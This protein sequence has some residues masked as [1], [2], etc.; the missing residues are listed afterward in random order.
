MSSNH[1]NYLHALHLM[2]SKSGVPESEIMAKLPFTLKDTAKLWYDN[3]VAEGI[4]PQTLAEWS[5]AIC[6]HFEND[7]WQ[8]WIRRKLD[9]YRYPEAERDPGIWIGKFINYAR[10]KSPDI[11][12]KQLRQ[13]IA[14]AMP[15]D[16]RRLVKASAPEGCTIIEYSEVFMDLADT[17]HRPS[18]SVR[19]EDRRHQAS[20]QSF[21]RNKPA[22]A[23]SSRTR[24]ST[25]RDGSGST[26][27]RDSETVRSD[28][29]QTGSTSATPDRQSS[30][31]AAKSNQKCY[32]CG[33]T[34]HYANDTKFHPRSQQLNAAET[35]DQ[36]DIDHTAS[37]QSAD[38]A[39]DQRSASDSDHDPFTV[40]A[41]DFDLPASEPFNWADCM[42]E[43]DDAEF[44]A[45]DIM[46]FAA[47]FRAEEEAGCFLFN[48]PEAVELDA[49]I[50]DIDEAQAIELQAIEPARNKPIHGKEPVFVTPGQARDLIDSG[51]TMIQE[52]ILDGNLQ[53]TD[54]HRLGR[55]PRVVTVINNRPLLVMIDSGA[56][57]SVITRKLLEEIE[58]HYQLQLKPVDIPAVV[59]FGTRIKPTGLYVTNVIFPHPRGNIQIQAAFLVIDV[60]GPTQILLGSDMT[61]MYGIDLVSSSGR[62]MKIGKSNSRFAIQLLKNDRSAHAEQPLLQLMAAHARAQDISIFEEALTAA[63]FSPNL[64]D[65]EKADLVRMLIERRRA[66]AWGT[67]QLGECKLP[68]L[69]LDVTIPDPIP[70]RLR[71]TPYPASPKTKQDISDMIDTLL[72]L[73]VIE[74]S[75]SPYAAPVVMVYQEGKGRL[76]VN[77]KAM[78]DI[79]VAF[80][81]PLPRMNETLAC[82]GSASYITVLDLNRGFYQCWVHPDSVQ[83]LTFCSHRGLFQF[84]RMPMGI[85]NGPA[86]FQYGMDT[87]LG[88]WLREGWVKV[89]LDDVIIFSPSFVEHVR[90][91]NTILGALE[92]AGMTVSIKKCQF[93]FGTL[94]ALGR[95]VSGL[96]LAIDPHKTA[97]VD[98]W[99]RPQNVKQLMS[100]SGFINY[101]RNHIPGLAKIMKPM[102]TLLLKDAS[103]EWTDA[104]E[105]AFIASKKALLS[106]EVLAM[107]DF[108]KPFKLYVDASFEGLGGE[109]SQLLQGKERPICFISRRLRP[110]EERYGA[111]QL[112]CLCLIWALEK[113]YFYLD[114]AEFTVYTD[115]QAI[116]S[117]MSVKNPNRHMLRWQ[118]AIQEHRGQMTVVHRAGKEN[119][120]ADGLSRCALPNDAS[121]PAADLSDDMPVIYAVAIVDMSDE[122]LRSVSAGMTQD[123][124]LARIQQALRKQTPE[125]KKAAEVDLSADMLKDFQSGRFFLLDDVLYRRQGLTSELVLGDT[126]N[127]QTMLK[128]CHDAITSG[129]FGF[130]KTYEKVKQ[131]AW[132]PHMADDIRKYVETCN[133]CQMS[134]RATGK[135]QGLLM[136]IETPTHPW[137][138]IHMDFVTALPPAGAD[139]FNACLVIADRATKKAKFLPTHDTATAK[140]T[141]YLYWQTLFADYGLPKAIISDRDPKFTSKFWKHLFNIL[142]VDLNM[143]TAHHPQT[144][145]LAERTV[146]TLVDLIRRYCAFG[147]SYRDGEGFKHDWVS[148]LPA[149]EQ[150]YNSSKHAS[151]DHSPFQLE[152]GWL[153][154]AP[155]A[156]MQ[157]AVAQLPVDHA[158][159]NF[160]EMIDKC[161]K[162]AGEV[163]DAAFEQ[164][165]KRFDAH[166]TETRITVGCKVLISTKHFGVIGSRKLKDPFVGPF[167]V[168]EMVNDNAARLLLTPPF[169]R[170]HDV[171]PVSMLK[172]S[173]SAEPGSVTDRAQPER[174]APLRMDEDGEPLYAPEKVMDQRTIRNELEYFVKWVDYAEPTWE[175]AVHLKDYPD[176]IRSFRA[177]Q[178][179]EARGSPLRRI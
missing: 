160:A 30:F 131:F 166:H 105:K 87:I 127:K 15:A 6:S 149:L 121:N 95:K 48:G 159:H 58:P 52:S 167:I 99:P 64:T 31:S 171:F 59:A 49:L 60:P 19:E 74:P 146:Q 53:V 28:R 164:A 13:D 70:A 144:D 151:T 33:Q 108:K 134:K 92:D 174:R 104:C 12:I 107:P 154:R 117:L 109:L 179:S 116:K 67:R 106:A 165:K 147:L 20:H 45:A 115:C 77:F 173:H 112:E 79:T 24:E 111:T 80:S 168:S 101:Y 50:V 94:R 142:G 138:V 25:H 176:L 128:A 86:H 119:T 29:A 139:N 78:N 110:S 172:L 122:W 82:I 7:A 54:M 34:G 137:E 120:N 66:F 141:A 83:Y 135:Q 5:D 14:S 145:G 47:H 81:Y 103:W 56:A 61:T 42:D 136:K 11:T 3:I 129:H 170:K 143:S 1:R 18:R 9:S 130:D 37:E 55:T 158:A 93:A 10:L 100:W 118:I 161:R 2:A 38:E 162:H 126:A 21:N 71:A 90:H 132:W 150:A 17:D 57:V 41:M 85:K 68:P 46:S 123:T 32:K 43:A 124:K 114:G 178:R 152:K 98:Q 27:R 84:K 169:D 96:D 35:D 97:A 75:Q 177:A 44:S 157:G 36:P 63:E 16:I 140:D 69:K 73:G 91:L 148:L 23:F 72:D 153:P 40:E 89:Y 102:N 156:L 22:V 8:Q 155:L 88:V 51:R 125:A 65:S 133:T 113:L 39:T 175:P 76:C 62:Y 26:Y 163:V 4:E